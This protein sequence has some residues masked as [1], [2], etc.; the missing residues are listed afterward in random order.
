MMRWREK[1]EQRLQFSGETMKDK[2]EETQRDRLTCKAILSRISN[3]KQW[4]EE[5]CLSL[6]LSPST[7]ITFK[8]DRHKK[9][10]FNFTNFRGWKKKKG[11]KTKWFTDQ[12]DNRAQENLDS[13]VDSSITFPKLQI[14]RGF[15]DNTRRREKRGSKRKVINNDVSVKD[16]PTSVKMKWEGKQ[17]FLRIHFKAFLPFSETESFYWTKV[18][19]QMLLRDKG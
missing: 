7:I 2:K 13:T 9:K 15:Q 11:K 4:E 10:K 5:V 16:D 1:K 17:S 8:G 6:F 19:E 12:S 3:R 18:W 14:H